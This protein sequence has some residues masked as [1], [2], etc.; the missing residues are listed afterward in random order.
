MKK[1]HSDKN[2]NTA[3]G[4]DFAAVILAAGYSS[5][6]KAFK[7]LLTIGDS[8]ALERLIYSAKM[9]G[10]AD[11]TVVTGYNHEAMS[12]VLTRHGVDEAY[13]E[14]FD[15]G[16]FSSIQKGLGEAKKHYPDAKGFFLMPVDCPLVSSE[17]IKKLMTAFGTYDE[18]VSADSAA[19]ITVDL[20][21]AANNCFHVP[22]YEGKKGHPLLIPASYIDEICD[23]E[24]NGG[25]KVITDKYWDKMIRVPVDSEGCVM[26]MDT[27]ESYKE[28]CDF[29][30][31]GC[32]RED[33][34]RLASGRRI[35]LVRHGETQQHDEKMFIGRYDVPLAE[36]GKPQV[37]RSA[38]E[39]LELI[40][41]EGSEADIS[42]YVS[43]L[44]RAQQSAEIIKAE[45]ERAGTQRQCSLCTVK[46]FQEI[47]LG[48]WDG[49]PVREI[50]ERYPEE[51]RRR[52]E[53]IFVFKTGNKSENFYDVQY[54]AVKALRRILE[55]DPAKDIIIV[56]HSAVI[57][58]LENNLKGMRVNDEWRSVPKGGFVVVEI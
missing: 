2:S 22:V 4:H 52:G 9:A 51:Y 12:G 41:G 19:C 10:I 36:E 48:K 7:P 50:K 16:M 24:G 33:I 49:R 6:M 3:A 57:R 38:S 39:I 40:Y 20:G 21:E 8:S 26:D 17:V 29:L 42:I 14:D 31:T 23:Y 54:R 11:I 46:D 58:A 5:R 1:L 15:S 28:I 55:S 47:S 25:L 18:D 27:P 53:D 32:R 43:P 45:L 37:R 44:K 56:A 30:E 34:C 13:N 35:F